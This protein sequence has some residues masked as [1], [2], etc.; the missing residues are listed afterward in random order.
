MPEARRGPQACHTLPHL[1]CC[2]YLY[3]DVLL[4]VL[5][6]EVK[7][8]DWGCGSGVACLPSTCEDLSLIHST[9]KAWGK[10]MGARPRVDVVC[11]C[12]IEGLSICSSYLDSET[13]CRQLCMFEREK[14]YLD[15][16]TG[17]F[18]ES[19]VETQ[20]SMPTARPTAL[21]MWLHLSGL[22]RCWMTSA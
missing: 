6:L 2:F 19:Q 11:C 17:I 13:L 1:Y 15:C 18:T 20:P 16:D 8:G 9:G 12:L 14:Q 10:G 3:R 22:P 7:K 21:C 4:F 5:I